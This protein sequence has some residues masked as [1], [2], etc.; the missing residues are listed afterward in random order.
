MRFKALVADDEYMIRRGIIS[1]LNRYEDFEVV[2]EAEDGEIALELAKENTVDVCFVDI[3]MP[4]LNGLQFIEKLKEVQPKALVVIITG[5]DSFEYARTAIK[6]R[7]FEYLLKPVMEDNFHKMIE[8]VRER[9]ISERSEGK[10][11]EWA[12]ETLNQN[13]SYLASSFLQKALEGH[14]SAE[15]MW[16]RFHYLGVEIPED[17]VVT[18]VRFE[19]QKAADVKEEW[20]DDLIFFVAEN[21]ANEIFNQMDSLRSCQNDCGDLIVVSQQTAE[22]SGQLQKYLTLM[23]RLVFVKCT[24][25]QKNGTGLEHLADVYHEAIAQVEEIMG[26]SSVIQ[27]VR[28]YV[29]QNYW[30]EDFSLQEAADCVNLSMQYMSKLFRKEMGVTFVDY[31]TSV[32][33]RKSI[34]L[35]Q[36]EELKIY[37]IAERVG[38]ATQ[39]YF[40][41][42]FKKNLG[43]SPAEYR[44]RIEER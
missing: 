21:M 25:I 9:L 10:Y 8:R 40:S 17:F 19:Y 35:F 38:Y 23:K 43:V 44:K 30:R 7:V 13:K 24:V 3:N 26:T 15:E 37:E 6:M 36:N 12:Q 14:F 32:R 41:T 31:L 11:L 28:E 16:E 22:Q 42:V 27:E 20:T 39:H 5:Y 2:A 1:F 33:I 18:V 34:D 29:E 4:F